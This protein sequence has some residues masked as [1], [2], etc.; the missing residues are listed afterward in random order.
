MSR[1]IRFTLA[2]C[3]F[4]ALAQAHE[5][6]TQSS[7]PPA[8]GHIVFPTSTHSAKAQDAFIEGM[9]LLHVFEYPSAAKAFQR[10]EQ[11]DPEFAMA[12][13]G[14]ALSYTHPVWNQQDLAAGRAALARLASTPAA[15]AAKTPTERERGFLQLAEIE[16]GEGPK[17]ERDL[18]LLAAAEALAL[19][20][21]DDDEAQLALS[22]A[23]LGANEGER[24]LPRFLRAAEIAKAV[25]RRNPQHP[26]AAHF[27]IHGLDDPEHAAGALE[28]AHALAKI[29]PGAGHSQHMTSHIFI[30][31]GMWQDVVDSNIAALRVV[32][33][34]QKADGQPLVACGHY[35]EWL[36]YAYFQQG[37]EREGFEMLHACMRAATT[38]KAWMRAHPGEAWSGM[39]DPAAVQARLNGSLLRMRAAAIFESPE[40][41]REASATELGL[42][43]LARGDAGTLFADGLAQAW[44]DEPARARRELAALRALAAAPAAQG[45]ESKYLPLMVQLLEAAIAQREGRGKTGLRKAAA[46]A[47]AFDALPYDFGPPVLGMPPRELLGEMLLEAG[48]KTEAAT[49]FELALKSAPNRRRS[50]QGLQRARSK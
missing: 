40:Y 17:P 45:Q 44:N 16:Y 49:Q 37:R 50:L 22:L 27:W 34:Q 46:A 10:A 28:A 5:P 11:L 23:L 6:S 15:R 2:L 31:L 3:C 47:D 25:Y 7:P 21:P 24:N 12:Y 8:L 41:R 43:E 48:R 1:P 32:N 29:A 9:L 18:K 20:W 36:Q 26:G 13:V 30:A 35:P 4:A 33:E 39:K 38:A 42:G 14:E 19:R